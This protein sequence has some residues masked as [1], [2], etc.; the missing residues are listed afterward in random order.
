MERLSQMVNRPY[1][2]TPHSVMVVAAKDVDCV[3][4]VYLQT[5]KK[6]SLSLMVPPPSSNPISI[7]AE[8]SRSSTPLPSPPLHTE[9]LYA[10]L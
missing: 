6:H 5:M 7:S 8:M 1:L 10:S 9:L 3:C 2:C 4:E